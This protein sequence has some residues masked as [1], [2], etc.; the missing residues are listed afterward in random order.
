MLLPPSPNPR[1]IFAGGGLDSVDMPGP[2]L[3][4]IS[5]RL[6]AST[7]R[8]ALPV[9]V[10][11]VLEVVASLFDCS[12]VSSVFLKGLG[13]ACDGWISLSSDD[14]SDTLGSKGSS[15]R[16]PG[17]GARLYVESSPPTTV[18]GVEG[19]SGPSGDAG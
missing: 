16:S 4:V 14:V 12:I 19:V 5:S 10:V 8:E 13:G 15:S 6:N 1:C 17:V 3:P 7:S 11:F 2:A 18:E 9:F